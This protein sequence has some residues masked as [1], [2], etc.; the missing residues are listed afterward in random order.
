MNGTKLERVAPSQEQGA[1]ACQ[2]DI[3][4][5]VIHRCK[6]CEMLWLAKL[7][8]FSQMLAI[9][10]TFLALKHFLKCSFELDT[11]VTNQEKPPA[12]NAFNNVKVNTDVHFVKLLR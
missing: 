5:K 4:Y 12:G 10:S 6:F 11:I 7:A 1:C 3:L 2:Q 8:L 9:F